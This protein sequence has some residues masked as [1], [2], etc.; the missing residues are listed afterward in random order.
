MATK[1]SLT[2]DIVAQ[3]EAVRAAKAEGKSKDEIK[4]LVAKLLNL[5]VSYKEVVGEEYAAPGAAS[6]PAKAAEPKV[7]QGPSKKEL[8]KMEKAKEAERLKEEKQAQMEAAKLEEE[9]NDISKDFYGNDKLNQSATRPGR[10]WCKIGDLN[11]GQVGQTVLLRARAHNVRGTGK[12]CFMVLRQRLDT[13]QAICAVDDTTSKLMVKFCT[14]VT[15]ESL[16]AVEGVLTQA[17]APVHACT[18]KNFELKIKKIFVVSSASPALP[19]QVEDASVP[20]SEL[21]KPDSVFK[22]IYQDVRLDNRI[23][24]LRTPANQAIFRLQASVCFLFREFLTSN[25]FTEIHTPKII[26]AASEGGANVFKC[27]Y[28][29][30]TAYLAQS[31]QLYKQ[32]AICGDLERVFEVTPVFRAEDSNTHRH[33][34]EFTGLDMEMEINEHYH[35]VMDMLDRLFVHIFKG[36][37]D[38]FSHELMIVSQQFP[39]E[40]FKFLEPSLR[41]NYVDGVKM[42]NE[43]G[44]AMEPT[45]DLTTANEKILGGLIKEKY[46]TDFYMLDKFPLCVRPFY[47]MPDPSNPLLSNSY[48][49]FMRGEEILSGAQRI[50]DPALLTERAN[51]HKIDLSTIQAY[52]DAFK[53]G[54]PPHGGGGI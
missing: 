16:I 1:E 35:E 24:D 43:A 6:K 54:A 23:I 19:F 11:P 45:E 15:R 8:R 40:G 34:T 17:P 9:R 26:P 37:R 10:T 33:L 50:H 5:K 28:F 38:R 18:Q 21:E 44:I 13:L 7:E 52:V 32:M 25:G 27:T 46:D 47:T 42:L 29:K 2:A 31:P 49:M 36:L 39:F 30:G 14:T 53:F 22:P 51:F 48:D 3:G 12:Q 41:I 20:E 4:E